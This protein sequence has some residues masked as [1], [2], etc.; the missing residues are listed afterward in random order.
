VLH[1]PIPTLSPL[2]EFDLRIEYNICPEKKIYLHIGA[3]DERKGT[4]HIL[5]SL[6]YIPVTKQKKICLILAGKASNGFTLSLTN[7]IE[8]VKQCDVQLIWIN[9][10]VSNSKM[11]SLFN[12]CDYVLI[13]YKNTEAS[14]GILG[15]A[16]ASEKIIIGTKGGLLGEIISTNNFGILIENVEPI[17][18]A[19]SM[20]NIENIT[21]NKKNAIKF[22]REHTLISFT[23]T[24]LKQ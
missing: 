24:I 1:D 17:A 13:P 12:Q 4:L 19:E 14:S 8:L 5:D 18:I 15:H 10:F 2:S 22:I 3:L 9:E 11:K 6:Q 7:K 23:E 21:F 16:V 20:I